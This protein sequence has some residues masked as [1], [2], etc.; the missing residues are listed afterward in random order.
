MDLNQAK[1]SGKKWLHRILLWGVILFVVG[2]GLYTFTSL[3]FSYSKGE[4][5]G[6]MQKMSKKG[7]I[8]KTNE[9]EL[10]MVNVAGQQ[11]TIFNFTVRDDAV[12]KQIDDLAGR[13]IVLEYEEHKGIPSSCFGDTP[14]FVVG[15]HEA[16]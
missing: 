12:M 15:V 13:R 10:A 14:Y 8:C 11:A 7:W 2:F 4:R 16:K 6:F 1:E 3:E 9:G 5:V